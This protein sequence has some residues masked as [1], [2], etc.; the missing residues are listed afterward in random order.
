MA[1]ANLAGIIGKQLETVPV[2]DTKAPPRPA[3]Q[4]TPAQ[5]TPAHSTPDSDVPKWLTFEPKPTRQRRDQLDWIEAKRKELNAL[6]GRAGE[7]LTDNTLIRVAIDL[8]IV[9]GERLQGTTE[10]ELRA[11]LGIID[12]AL[13][14]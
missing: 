6:R 4:S 1:R 10:A 5:S 13:P 7:R 14:K 2:A 3:A 9:N 11:S 8:L 12:D